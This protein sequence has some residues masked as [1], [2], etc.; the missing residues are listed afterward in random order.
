MASGFVTRSI[1][2]AAGRVPGLRRIPVFKLVAIAEVGMLAREHLNR[3]TPQER[4]RL[5]ELVRLG[6][7]RP[8]N[9]KGRQRQELA[10]LVAKLE[11]RMFAGAAA[12]KLSPVPLPKRMLRGGRE[13]D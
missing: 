8:S 13:R 1:A 2:G 5:I 4:R 12:D 10:W 11:P 7:G 3:L 9:L 6:R